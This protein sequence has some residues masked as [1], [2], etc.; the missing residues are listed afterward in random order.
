MRKPFTNEILST[1]VKR[2]LTKLATIHLHAAFQHED[3]AVDD[4]HMM[5]AMVSF[6]ALFDK[7]STWDDSQRVSTTLHWTGF[8]WI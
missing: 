1:C 7:E 5:I 8:H 4:D 3:A 6:D 2:S